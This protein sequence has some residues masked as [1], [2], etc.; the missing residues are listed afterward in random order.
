VEGEKMIRP[1]RFAADVQF[2]YHNGFCI[3]YRTITRVQVMINLRL[4]ET[5]ERGDWS[6]LSTAD[7]EEIRSLLELGF[8]VEEPAQ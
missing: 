2:T 1:V 4:K 8:L 3:C 7:E 5:I 6:Q